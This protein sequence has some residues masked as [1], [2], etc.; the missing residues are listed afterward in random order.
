MTSTG[1]GKQYLSATRQPTLHLKDFAIVLL[2]WLFFQ[3]IWFLVLGV[4]FELEA[5]KYIG[6]AEYLLTHQQVS[7][8]RYLFYITTVLVITLSFL[9]KLGLTGALLFIMFINL[10]AYL[11][12]YKALCFF[13]RERLSPLLVIVML[14]SF[15]PY[16]SWSL[17]LYTECI[18][19]SAVMLLFAHLLLFRKLSKGYMVALLSMLAFVVFSR[20]LGILFVP[21]ILLFIFFKLSKK[22][23]FFFLG[24]VFFALVALNFIV[25]VVFTT[26]RD[27]DMQRA[28]TEGD[29]ICDIPGEKANSL[30]LTNHSNQLYR[31]FYYI[32]HNF[33]HFF[34]LAVV[35]LRYF[36]T[37]VRSYYSP[38]HNGFLIA[39][40]AIWYG[41]FLIGIKKIVSVFP[42]ALLAFVISAIFLFAMTVA[43]QCDDYH[44]RFFLTLSPF[45]SVFTIVALKPL[46]CR[47]PFFAKQYKG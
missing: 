13:F 40:L 33:D 19:Y 28:I 32:T 8:P 39:V 35:R 41:C 1:F 18:F 14:L 31:L 25:Q 24:A 42:A 44:N 15:W 37:M 11:Y 21:P 26:T 27:W 17:Y 7:S 3:V 38:F 36:F 23:R 30:I 5:E 9:L 12:F 6:E 29:V 43:M 2:S 16:Q 22:Q 20:P 10:V 45:F 46:I 4:H 34:A 47:I